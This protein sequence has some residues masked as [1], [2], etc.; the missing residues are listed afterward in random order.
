MRERELGSAG[1]ASRV[2]GTSW[3]PCAC[4]RL[5]VSS[6]DVEDV[7]VGAWE[8]FGR[9]FSSHFGISLA[10]KAASKPHPLNEFHAFERKLTPIAI[11]ALPSSPRARSGPR[12]GSSEKLP[13]VAWTLG[14]A[15]G[16][17]EL[18]PLCSSPVWPIAL[19]PCFQSRGTGI[20]VTDPCFRMGL[21]QGHTRKFCVDVQQGGMRSNFGPAGTK[22]GQ[23]NEPG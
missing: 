12:E 11:Q 4:W 22:E 8:L 5:L 17:E 15:S 19:F 3:L 6:W 9:G 20:L 14:M 7:K 23:A 16:Q 10:G 18:T 2:L 1:V 21:G 13:L